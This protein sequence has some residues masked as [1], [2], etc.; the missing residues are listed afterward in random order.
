MVRDEPGSYLSLIVSS[1]SLSSKLT[2][3][4]W[5]SRSHAGPPAS[6][7]SAR[8]IVMAVAVSTMTSISSRLKPAHR[9]AAAAPTVPMAQLPRRRRVVSASLRIG[10]RWHRAEVEVADGKASSELRRARV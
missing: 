4:A 6:G 10:P 3:A 8:W 7:A 5:C 1:I 9:L 2:T